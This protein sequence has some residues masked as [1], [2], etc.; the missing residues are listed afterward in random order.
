[1]SEIILKTDLSKYEVFIVE[2]W[3]YKLWEIIEL[4]EIVEPQVWVLTWIT[5]QH[6]DR[7]KSIENIAKAKFELPEFIDKYWL[8]V[9]DYSNQYIK[10]YLDTK[11]NIKAK[12][13]KIEDSNVDY[14][15]NFEW[16]KFTYDNKEFFSKL[17]AWH[18]AKNFITAYEI[19]KYFWINSEDIIKKLA[20]IEPVEHRL[21]KIVN[22]N[23]W[24]IVIDD[25]Y[26][27]NFEWVKS[28]INMLSSVKI[29]WKKLYLTP[30]L[31]ELAEKSEEIHKQIWKMLADAKIDKVLLIDN[32][33][34]RNIEAWLL[35]N[36]F[37]KENI[38]FFE[39][40]EIAHKNIWKYL[41][42]SDA[43]VFQNDF[44]DNYF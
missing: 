38:V 34:A 4:C 17:L 35:E 31:V 12:I 26:N 16:F 37:N 18:S 3:A 10:N 25:S 15:D 44:T 19:W 2:M 23:T 20:E 1:M 27:W 39:S 41:N 7:F 5:F 6:L 32:K 8:V 36:W 33:W 22:P 43:V 14:L 11:A 28:T 13:I 30:W 42:N 9:L 29:S 24:V 40:T 21:S